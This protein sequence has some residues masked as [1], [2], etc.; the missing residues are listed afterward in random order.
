MGIMESYFEPVSVHPTAAEVAT[1]PA[2]KKV[3]T[4]EAGD[5]TERTGVEDELG[6][7][8]TACL[9]I[10]ETRPANVAQA[11]V[12]SRVWLR[13]M[14]VAEGALRR[15]EKSQVDLIGAMREH[16]VKRICHFGETIQLLSRTCL[17]FR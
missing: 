8:Q 2:P 15:A 4:V 7:L 1:P 6:A 11:L 5:Q 12:F 17:L 14:V 16:A 13:R 3:N 9:P 10:G